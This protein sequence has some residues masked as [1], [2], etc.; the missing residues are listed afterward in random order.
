MMADDTGQS[1]ASP[2][3]DP[4]MV[5]QMLQQYAP[6]PPQQPSTAGMTQM[7]PQMNEPQQ[8]PQSQFRAGGVVALIQMLGKKL[9]ER[10]QR[11]TQQTFD[12][13]TGSVKGIQQ[14]QSQMQEA[15]QANKAAIQKFQQA[16][17]PD[18]KQAAQQEVL[19]TTQTMKKAQEAVQQNRTNLDDMFSGP[20]AERHHKMLAKGFGI[21]DKNADT[22]ERKAAI[23]AM[24]KAMGVDKQT[25]S[26]L[27][28]MPQQQ[29]LSPQAQ[30]Q[31]MAQ[32]AGVQGKPATA[33]QQLAADTARRGQ[34]MKAIEQQAG[35]MEKQ[36][37]SAAYIQ[38]RASKQGQVAEKNAS[39]E[40][41]M[42]PMTDGEK[43]VYGAAQQG[44][45]AWTM[46]DGKPISVLRNPQTNQIIPGSENPALLPPGYLTEHIHEGNYFWT[47]NDGNIHETPV[48]SSTK[49]S[50]PGSGK[51]TVTPLNPRGPKADGTAPAG[52]GTAGDKVI[53][54]GKTPPANME[55]RMNFEKGYEKPAEDAEKSYQ[56]ASNAYSEYSALQKQ[57]KDFPSGAQSMLMLSQHLQTTFGNV[58]GARV[59]K[60]MIHEHL[61]AR[62]VSDE[63]HV[64]VQKLVD[65]DSLSPSQWEAFHDLIGQ[66]RK[67]SWEIAAKEAKRAKVPNDFTPPDLLK[68]GVGAPAGFVKG[69]DGAYVGSDN[70]TVVG[71]QIDGKY[72]GE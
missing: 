69:R 45:I 17:T 58:K 39:G 51:H 48:T 41:K 54:K 11:E 60:D 31:Q 3:P 25:A 1:A 5:A 61:G 42:R 7:G 47:D 9:G 56:M 70:K 37:V 12:T 29:Q 46:K 21:D 62:G 59:T 68:Q 71:W 16:K 43:T 18:E 36:G 34:D 8:K 14:G 26:L 49:P 50:L 19:Q 32:R 40:W 27:S 52:S 22:P 13:F 67:E 64:A 44:K 55:L 24:Q 4:N 15:Q 66:S 23:Q 30:Q 2:Q 38:M 6:K 72:V 63:A 10:K 65:G 35:L 53:G 33:G 28:R 20:K 57:G